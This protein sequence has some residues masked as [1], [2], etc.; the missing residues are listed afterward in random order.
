MPPVSSG[1]QVAPP[2]F[3]VNSAPEVSGAKPTAEFGNQASSTF[4]GVATPTLVQVCP[5]S[6]ERASVPA[7]PI[8]VTSEVPLARS[9]M[10]LEPLSGLEPTCVKLFAPSSD[11]T[12]APP[13][14]TPTAFEAVLNASAKIFWVD[15]VF[16]VHI[17]PPSSVRRI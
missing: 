9:R 11:T 2:S 5:P 3:D 4:W 15:A 14:P 7:L 12:V 10:N 1:D 13:C 6:V 16:D 8:A 17:V